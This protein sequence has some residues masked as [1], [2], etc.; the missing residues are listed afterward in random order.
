[1]PPIQ[2]LI[3][4]VSGACNM[5]CRYCFYADEMQHRDT[6]LLGRMEYGTLETIVRKTL[7][8][9][10]KQCM[11]VFQGGEPTLAGLQFYQ[12]LDE[13]V[14]KY[15]TRRLE[16]QYAIQTNG[17]VIDRAWAEWLAEHH[18]LVGLSL[19]GPRNLHDRYRRD[20]RGEGTFDRAM[21]AADLFAQYGVQFNILC[22]VTA[23]AARNITN[24]YQ[25]YKKHNFLYQ[26][27]IP[28]LE[29]L[30][31]EG[32]GS[33][34]SLTP[35]LY[36]AF[37]KRLFDLWYEDWRGGTYIYNRT[38]ENWIGMIRGIPPE[39]CGMSGRC[40]PQLV[41]EAT[42]MVYPCDFYV[43]DPYELGN[44]NECSFA[45][46]ERRRAEIG[47]IQQS[48]QLDPACRSCRWGFLCRGGCRRYREPMSAQ[49]PQKNM[50]CTAFQS[51]FAYA[52]SRMAQ[53]ASEGRQGGAK[54]QTS[55]SAPH[56]FPV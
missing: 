2:L 8:H 35:P 56:P 45:E 14:A 46:I 13:F 1:M 50:Y 48:G 11:F 55:P 49:A 12:K 37:L 43:L 25:F 33:A 20:A 42:G 40:S 30:G 32:S 6:P 19:D 21:Q 39:L 31:A 5:R 51:F 7:E 28:C 23:Q 10:E 24:I 53:M 38:F 44:L 26:Q 22:V 3:K 29:P 47:F 9:S 34:Y 16:V 18:Y 17:Y 36:G 52:W 54:Q 4:P 27:Y 41:V 15:N